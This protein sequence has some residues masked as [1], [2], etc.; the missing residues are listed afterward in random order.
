M[1]NVQPGSTSLGPMAVSERPTFWKAAMLTTIPPMQ[2]YIL[3]GQCLS[4]RW[5]NILIIIPPCN[6]IEALI[7]KH[8]DSSKMSDIKRHYGNQQVAV[9]ENCISCC[10]FS[11]KHYY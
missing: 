6:S 7:D 2:A 8:E 5:L 9:R 1:A 10:C 11:D 4:Y 3:D